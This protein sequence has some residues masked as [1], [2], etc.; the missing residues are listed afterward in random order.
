MA[1][2]TIDNNKKVNEILKITQVHIKILHVH[3]SMSLVCVV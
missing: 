3:V 2:G 1:C